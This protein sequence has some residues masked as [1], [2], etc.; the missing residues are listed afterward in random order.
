MFYFIDA[1]DLI[2]Q[3]VKFEIIIKYDLLL[4]E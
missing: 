1:K 4:S 2:K 3:Q